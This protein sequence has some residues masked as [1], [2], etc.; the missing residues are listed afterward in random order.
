MEVSSV[1]V[2]AAG[3]FGLHHLGPDIAGGLAAS[4]RTTLG[5]LGRTSLTPD[6]VPALASGAVRT[7]AFAVLPIAGVVALAG[8][9]AQLV[10]V[11]P[12]FPLQPLQPQWER[13]SPAAG[14]KRIVSKRAMLELIKS[15]LKIAIVAALIVGTLADAPERLF[16]LATLEP[17]AAFAVIAGILLKMAAA[18]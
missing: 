10:Q 14:F 3:L 16:D 11:G 2:F 8:V 13:I 7:M 9:V 18:A 17:A 5:E 1:V 15:L 6:A 12:L 4:L